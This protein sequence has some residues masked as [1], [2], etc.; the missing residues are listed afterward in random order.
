ME[1]TVITAL[2][3]LVGLGISVGGPVVRLNGSITR[4]NT[5]LQAMEARLNAALFFCLLRLFCWSRLPFCQ[6]GLCRRKEILFF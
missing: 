4:L 1:W 2:V 5:L 3:T 6:N